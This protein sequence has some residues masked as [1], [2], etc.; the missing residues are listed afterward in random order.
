MFSSPATRFALVF[1][2]AF[3]QHG[4]AA[5][6]GKDLL[7][8]LRDG[9][10]AAAHRLIK[11]GSFANA[12][13]ETGSSALMYAAVYA[14]LPV[15]R[16]LL[17]HGADPNHADKSGATALMWAVPDVEK[18]RLLI[19]H[20]ANVNAVSAPTGRTPLLIA[21]GRPGAARI[22]RMRGPEGARQGGRYHPAARGV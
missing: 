15:M 21:A 20:G 16:A 18:V 11:S 2:G 17:D 22:V 7:G 10:L 6:S 12:A 3:L 1:I 13:D 5:P 8:V 4:M 19:E 9:D 14:D